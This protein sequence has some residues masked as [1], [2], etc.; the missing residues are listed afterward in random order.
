METKMED[1]IHNVAHKLAGAIYELI[2][3][4]IS[5]HTGLKRRKVRKVIEGRSQ[6]VRDIYQVAH[7]VGIDLDVFYDMT[8]KK[9]KGK[10]DGKTRT[11]KKSTKS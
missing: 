6:S 9:S 1:Q 11:N 5:N 10:S 7:A 4:E 8:K 2:V 3:S